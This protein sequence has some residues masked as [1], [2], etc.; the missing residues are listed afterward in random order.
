MVCVVF[1]TTALESVREMM[2]KRESVDARLPEKR[3]T[4]FDVVCYD[5][6]MP[7][8]MRRQY[9]HTRALAGSLT[10]IRTVNSILLDTPGISHAFSYTRI[11]KIVE[12]TQIILLAESCLD[13]GCQFS[14]GHVQTHSALLKKFDRPENGLALIFCAHCKCVCAILFLR[15]GVTLF[16]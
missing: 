6:R 4:R 2:R 13:F 16:G 14:F 15:L 12:V 11:S 9:T 8:Y 5:Q 3:K 7:V 1:C 10:Y